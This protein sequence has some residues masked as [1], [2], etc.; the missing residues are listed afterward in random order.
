MS[1]PKQCFQ[2]IASTQQLGNRSNPTTSEPGAA[3]RHAGIELALA[4]IRMHQH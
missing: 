1:M 2:V 4:I 3:G